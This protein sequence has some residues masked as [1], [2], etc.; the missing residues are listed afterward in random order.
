MAT[1]H[2]FDIVLVGGGLQSGLI[3]LSARLPA[4]ATARLA[5]PPRIARTRL[6]VSSSRMRRPRPAPSASRTATSFFRA[7]ARATCRLARFTQAI[8]RTIATAPKSTSNDRRSPD[9]TRIVSSGRATA[10]QRAGSLLV[11]NVPASIGNAS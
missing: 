10:V 6:S 2:R 7:T 4:Q 11:V 8:S 3:A 1:T 5:A 9:A